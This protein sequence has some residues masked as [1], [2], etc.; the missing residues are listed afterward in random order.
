M[1]HL[2]DHWKV[3]EKL[4]KMNKYS[5][6]SCSKT[7]WTVIISCLARFQRMRRWARGH[8]VVCSLQLLALWWKADG[9]RWI[10]IISNRLSTGP[11]CGGPQS[12]SLFFSFW[13]RMLTWFSRWGTGH[14]SAWLKRLGTC[15]K[16]TIAG[17][18]HAKLSSSA[19]T[20]SVWK[21]LCC[22]GA[23]QWFWCGMQTNDTGAIMLQIWIKNGRFKFHSDIELHSWYDS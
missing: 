14:N 17:L 10:G 8:I 20:F 19:R 7:F 9:M 18:K 22:S 5:R 4:L 16:S 3:S 2:G 1:L 21:T 23:A 11:P 12:S 15:L 6:R 13:K